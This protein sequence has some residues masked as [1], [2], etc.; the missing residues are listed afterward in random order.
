MVTTRAIACDLASLAAGQAD[1]FIGDQGS[2]ERA[3]SITQ[4]QSW[5]GSAGRRASVN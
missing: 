1:G 5:S 2:W 3:D 4:S